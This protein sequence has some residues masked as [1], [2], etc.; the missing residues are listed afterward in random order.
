[1]C[2]HRCVLWSIRFHFVSNI[3][4][5][6]MV[7]YPILF[8]RGVHAC[9]LNMDQ[10]HDFVITIISISNNNIIIIDCLWGFAHEDCFPSR[11]RS[12]GIPSRL[13]SKGIPSR[14]RR[15]GDWAR[16]GW[17]ACFAFPGPYG[18]ETKWLISWHSFDRIPVSLDGFFDKNRTFK[19]K[20]LQ[21][22]Q[23]W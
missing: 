22:F 14:L 20:Y 4:C 19:R 9:I 17:S 18:C 1:M 11:L 3:L 8:S 5:Y 21:G 16:V 2:T 23:I 12:Q 13:R 7:P 6:L 15:R 10:Y